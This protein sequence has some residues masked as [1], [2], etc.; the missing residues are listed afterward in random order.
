MNKLNATAFKFE[1]DDYAGDSRQ[2][3]FFDI[4]E[5]SQ[6]MLAVE[7]MA[8]LELPKNG[9]SLLNL[10]N[11]GCDLVTGNNLLALISRLCDSQEKVSPREGNKKNKKQITKKIK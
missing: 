2:V 7:G 9:V 6:T 8:F 4:Q 1:V 3:W 11:G 5:T 10:I